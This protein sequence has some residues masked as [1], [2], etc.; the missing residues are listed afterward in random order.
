[1]FIALLHAMAAAHCKAQSAS[2]IHSLVDEVSAANIEAHI[3]AL[4]NGI[5]PRS[6]IETRAAAA[7]YIA[8]QLESFGYTV[9]RQPVIGA[10]QVGENIVAQLP[11]TVNPDKTFVI[12]AHFD[13][14]G[15]SP[16]ADD[17]TSGVAAVLEIARAV[18]DA[19]PD[20]SLE[21][22]GFGLEEIGIIGSRE[23]A[24]DAA[25]Q[26]RELIGAVS[27]EMIGY[28][29]TREDSQV[30]VP[31]I[32]NCL[33]MSEAS[34]T[35][36]DFIGAVGNDNSVELIERFQQ[37]A[38]QYVP[39]LLVITGQVAGNGE[40][41]PDTRRSDHYR[42]WE[43]G[44]QA[45]LLT[46]T[47]EYRNPH[48]HQPSDTLATLDLGFAR[49]VTQATLATA[50][51]STNMLPGDFDGDTL[52]SVQ[53]IDLLTAEIRKDEPRFWFDADGNEI[54]DG[55]DRTWWV[56]ELKNTYFGDANLDG[57]FNS[58]DLTLVLQAGQYEDGIASNS[59]WATGDWN[60]DNE[61]DTS[62][63]V[64]A[65][66]DAGI[67]TGP[68][69]AIAN[70]PEPATLSCWAIVGLLLV[71][72]PTRRGSKKGLMTGGRMGRKHSGISYSHNSAIVVVLFL[73]MA[74]GGNS[75]RA[76]NLLV[77]GG[78][79]TFEETSPGI[80]TTFGD[81]QG[82]GSEIRTAENGIVPF[83]GSSMLRFLDTLHGQASAFE[84]ADIYQH[85]DL[86]PYADQISAGTLTLRAEAYFNRVAGDERTDTRFDIKLEAHS[87]QPVD[88]P[89]ELDDATAVLFSDADVTTW[90]PVILEYVPPVGTSYIAMKV[91]AGEDVFNDLI[92]AEFDGHYVDAVELTI[93]SNHVA[94]DLNGDGF[95]DVFDIEGLSARIRN[96]QSNPAWDVDNNGALDSDDRIV[97]VHELQGTYFGDANLDGEFNSGD[98]IT[99][100][101]TG[102]YE[103]G[104]IGNSTWA[105][106]DWNGDGDFD[107]GDFLVAFQD[108]GFEQGPRPSVRAVP[109]PTS[110]V[111]VAAGLIVVIVSGR[112]TPRRAWR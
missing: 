76:T 112:R 87:G 28:R 44:Y 104:I 18:K 96:G 4:S 49:Q 54:V 19:R 21:F 13:T 30:P 26:R 36:G 24:R 46:D 31:N 43:E 106:G 41:F 61:F 15:R 103:D 59:T 10:A 20:F 48:Y 47:A 81:W 85:F 68:R 70:V 62:D 86:Q 38:T 83:E 77:N 60:G 7:N 29:S 88:F 107:S 91:R 58:G 71:G 8:N 67:E 92:G 34:R 25:A 98:L 57:E 102:Q 65:F 55:D 17:N 64:F 108:G 45:L 99:V 109:E 39:E 78:F 82:D 97:W 32:P 69:Q 89:M 79:E 73:I 35:V 6:T 2:M 23:Y 42:F 5:G 11:G 95:C 40:C 56:H 111:L 53:D 14:V 105:S 9:T 12:G 101:E 33:A 75:V 22:V 27:L 94:C 84:N 110:V 90:E 3:D 93:V 80:P 66:Q 1:M 72:R 52:L 51:V 16:G 63:L 37:A 100:L 50:L 74:N